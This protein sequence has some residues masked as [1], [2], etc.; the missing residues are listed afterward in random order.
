MGKYRSP[1]IDGFGKSQ[2]FRIY[3][4]QSFDKL[5]ILLTD[6]WVKRLNIK[7]LFLTTLDAERLRDQPIQTTVGLTNYITRSTK[8]CSR[9]LEKVGTVGR[10]AKQIQKENVS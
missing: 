5:V 4:K 1:A 7:K 3:N 9:Q 10:T 2:P 6:D 8:G